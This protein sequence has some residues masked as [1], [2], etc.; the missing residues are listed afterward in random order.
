[1]LGIRKLEVGKLVSWKLGKVDTPVCHGVPELWRGPAAKRDE[2]G[3]G[4]AARSEAT[5][6]RC[7]RAK[8]SHAR[9]QRLDRRGLVTSQV[10]SQLSA[11]AM[12]L[13]VAG[14]AGLGVGA[15]S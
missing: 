8:R 9:P 1:M 6:R 15:R 12:Q 7:V 3:G 10:S 2:G 4:R 5:V 11:R 13:E 14:R